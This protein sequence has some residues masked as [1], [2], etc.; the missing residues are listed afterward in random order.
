MANVFIDI[1]AEFTGKK[2]FKEAETSTDKLTKGVK[3]LGGA[4]GLAFG[5][6]QIVNYGKRAVKAFADS[7]LEATRLRVA[8]TNLGLAFAAPEIDRYIDKVE[9][10][11]G[12][13]R[14]Q[15]Q[16]AFLTLLQTTGSLTK[17]QELL[18]LALD[19]S[20]ATGAD[21]SS[22]A[23]KLS[24]AYLGNTKGLKSLNLG[25][26]TAELNS[27]DFETIQKRIA[28]LFAGQAQAA[29]D[30]YTGQ[31]NKLA[32]AS[33]QAS[34]IIGGGLVD[35]LLILSG[36]TDVSAL[37]DD[38]L[39]AAYN[40][41]EFT[42]SVTELATAINAPI[43]GLADIVA[44][45]V[46]ATDP[47]VD[48]I[49]EG[50][51]SGFFNKKPQSGANAPRAAFNGK[52]FYADAQKNA[53]ALAKAESDAKKRAAELLAI[54]KKQQAAE[55][56]TLR[57]KKLAL[58][59][60]KANIALNKGS[61]VFDLDKIQVAAALTNQAEQLGKATSSAQLLQIT[62]DTA[63][64][65]VKES[66]SALEDAIASK[67]EAA[68]I[69][70]TNR[71][72]ADNKILGSLIN[73]D[74]KMKDI[75]TILE[76][77]KPKD[78]IN[79]G[80]LDAAIAK[81]IELNRL[82]NAKA[83]ATDAAA[84]A[85]EA[86]AQAVEASAQLIPKNTTD[87]TLNNPTIFKLID[88]MLPSNSYNEQLVTA[89]NA[90]AD[91]PSAVRGS[92]Y[93]ARAEQEYAAFLSQIN[94]G[95]IAGQSLTSGMAQGLPLSNALSGSRYAA[96]AAASYGAGATIVVNTGVGDPNAIAEAIDQVL[97]EAR[98]RGTLTVG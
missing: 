46:K 49:I 11:T 48:L 98:D 18:N 10:A 12:V 17:S 15:L 76:G 95:G 6:Q 64:L 59:I 19:V 5:T 47:F 84:K 1:L 70:A 88:K 89:L 26:T 14:D 4:L 27:A 29:A 90:G 20:A 53:D 45:F 32:I 80:N 93:Q 9:L 13:N 69:A 2:A 50:D 67:D 68:I 28:A 54:K 56:K 40:A 94:M 77:L 42:R 3:K 57:D 66:I 86:A 52:P 38:M 30:S 82:Q 35:S 79:L 97:R 78:L 74:L 55:A 58:L 51:P 62:N 60:D 16:P 61:E 41:A 83:P 39:T 24:Q 71:L 34:E 91:L 31:I 23:E 87:F 21:A 33:E 65:R 36:N 73:Q 22:V 63:R 37:A 7:E 92:N 8:V 85:A 25:L 75:K 43:K 72:N 81:M 96:Q 44:R